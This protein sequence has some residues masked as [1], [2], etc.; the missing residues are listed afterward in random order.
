MKVSCMMSSAPAWS[1][2]QLL[3]VSVQGLGM[4][5]NPLPDSGIG[6]AA[7]PVRAS[8]SVDSHIY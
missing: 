2:A 6:V 1:G 5:R 8:L 7:Q 4:V 3:D